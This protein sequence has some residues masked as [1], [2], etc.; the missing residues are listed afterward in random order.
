[1]KKPGDKPACFCMPCSTLYFNVDTYLKTASFSI[2][3]LTYRYVKAKSVVGFVLLRSF[4]SP[5]FVNDLY[6]LFKIHG[7][8]PRELSIHF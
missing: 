1:V 5:L 4:S 7:R 2:I 8:C 6:A 3:R